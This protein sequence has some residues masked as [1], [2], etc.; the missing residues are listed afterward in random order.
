MNWKGKSLETIGELTDAIGKIETR[1]EAEDFMREYRS[2]NEFADANIGY[3]T[4]YF[5]MEKMMK[6]QDLF[7]VVHPVF[8]SK[9]P[10]QKEAFEAGVKIGKEQS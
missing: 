1:E 2:E 6:L 10:T 8:G 4:G 7:S 9:V 3:L 5:S